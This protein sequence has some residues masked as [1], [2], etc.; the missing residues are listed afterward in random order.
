MHRNH[1]PCVCVLSK[2]ECRAPDRSLAHAEN[3]RSSLLTGPSLPV[4]KGLFKSGTSESVFWSW[5]GRSSTRRRHHAAKF[6]RGRLASRWA[7]IRVVNTCMTCSCCASSLF[8]SCPAL[9]EKTVYVPNLDHEAP[10][11]ITKATCRLRMRMCMH[12]RRRYLRR[13]ASLVALLL[14]KKLQCSR[15]HDF[16]HSHGWENEF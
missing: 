1:L 12:M 13:L 3:D 6:I 2:R 15:A 11:A 8:S 7:W 4:I 10:H 9:S 14:A 5:S 16:N